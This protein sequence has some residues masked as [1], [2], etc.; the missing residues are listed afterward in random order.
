M[1]KKILIPIATALALVIISFPI[2]Q[3]FYD[4][5]FVGKT[6]NDIEI[7]DE[8][9]LTNKSY[10][11]LA[12]VGNK[13]Y[14]NYEPQS[15]VFDLL[16]YG[17][18]EISSTGT[19]RVYWGGIKITDGSN[20]FKVD[21]AGENLI[22]SYSDLL[23]EDI[24]YGEIYSYNPSSKNFEIINKLGKSTPAQIKACKYVNGRYFYYLQNS[25][26]VQ[27]GDMLEK[28]VDL[29]PTLYG[30]ES[31]LYRFFISSNC[32]VYYIKPDGNTCVLCRYDL[33]EKK[34]TELTSVDLPYKEVTELYIDGDKAVIGLTSDE[35]NISQRN[36]MYV[37]DIADDSNLQELLSKTTD[38]GRTLI[39]DG[40]L[41]FLK[42]KSNTN[43]ICSIELSYPREESIIYEGDITNIHIV[44]GHGVYFTDSNKALYR[45]S[46]NGEKLETV[47][48]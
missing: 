27:N 1:K 18:Y 38:Y 48:G 34:E 46:L 16:D 30:D 7:S 32:E 44:D 26:Y 24:S 6:H 35:N 17:L 19:K 36:S 25:L 4:G 37:A 2:Y 13:L 11:E 14:Y 33:S 29:Q 5:A 8:V 21:S 12:K 41:Y 10:G 23:Y 40:R 42:H 47:F 3:I 28:I 45:A 22:K 20:L 9:V 31:P 15:N 43:A 39:Y